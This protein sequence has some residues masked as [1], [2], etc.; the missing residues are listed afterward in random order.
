M[1]ARECEGGGAVSKLGG[2]VGTVLVP[3][4]IPGG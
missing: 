3:A 2:D 4:G 1:S